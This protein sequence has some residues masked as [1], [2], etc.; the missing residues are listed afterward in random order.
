MTKQEFISALRVKLYGLPKEEIEERLAFYGEMIDDRREEGLSE[1]E[2][3]AAIG[4]LDGIVFEIIE[5][6][7]LGKLIKEKAK[8]KRRFRA[9]EIVLLSLGA[10]LW[11]SL[12]ASVF[13]V[14][15]SLYASL[16]SVIS[17]FWAA[18]AAVALGALGG[19]IVSVGAAVGGEALVA[20]SLFGTCVA[21]AGLA[22]F[23]F[24]GT[25]AATKGACLLSK[26]MMIGIK[27]C[28]IGKGE[29]K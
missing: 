26:K 19:L 27:K 15:L 24:F 14:L 3:V 8:R 7:P 2:A 10:P 1:E 9:W 4:T 22:I 17:S 20:I 6:V 29:A 28:F 23:F 25:L 11:I 21:L 16:W 12:L 13:A 5:D 18:F